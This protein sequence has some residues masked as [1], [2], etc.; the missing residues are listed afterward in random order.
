[1]WYVYVLENP[2]MHYMYVGSTN[3]LKRRM[4]EH[5]NGESRATKPYRPLSLSAYIAVQTEWKARKLEKY[6]KTGS[7]KTILKKRILQLKVSPVHR[8]LHT[9]EPRSPKPW[10]R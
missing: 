1:M 5:N 7:G 4:T 3:N 10:R 6:L 8:S 9:G 2:A